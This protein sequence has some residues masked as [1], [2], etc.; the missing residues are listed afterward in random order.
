MAE[1]FF[2]FSS[3]SERSDGSGG[4]DW[5]HIAPA[6]AVYAA[7]ASAIDLV[8][9]PAV[10]AV[11]APVV[12]YIAPAFG[13][14]V[15]EYIA[16][17]PG[18]P[19]GEYIAPAFGVSVG[20]YIAPAPGVPVG[21]YIAPAP[22]VSVVEYIAPAPGAPVGEY[23]A[24]VPA[25]PVVEYIAPAPAVFAVPAPVVENIAF[26][27]VV[28]NLR[29]NSLRGA[30]PSGMRHRPSVAE[31]CD[32]R[33]ARV[34]AARLGYM[35]RKSKQVERAACDRL[36]ADMGTVLQYRD[37]LV[38]IGPVLTKLAGRGDGVIMPSVQHFALQQQMASL[39]ATV[40]NHETAILELER[41]V[42]SL[43]T[44]V[45]SLDTK[46]REVGELLSESLS[47]VEDRFKVIDEDFKELLERR[48]AETTSVVQEQ[49]VQVERFTDS[50][51][52]SATV[53]RNSLSKLE[54]RVHKVMV[55]V[56]ALGELCEALQKQSER[57]TRQLVVEE[58][59]KRLRDT[60]PFVAVVC[61]M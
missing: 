50:V 59:E 15:G 43:E 25:V 41:Q 29:Q 10:F 24:P 22:G 61:S 35:W 16:P 57:V 1:R 4:L 5:E 52:Q 38:E 11:P 37:E 48:T 21:E 2:L 6:P 17:A 14:S 12:E 26:A 40:A 13:V 33:A 31:K 49:M 19:V 55:R 27:P 30:M 46:A 7:P 56:S 23:I 18:V 20:E 9:A 32:T 51:H 34:V 44:G 58:M 53:F 39:T 60:E 47:V 28:A 42:A 8:P 36:L 3:E 54:N 45:Q